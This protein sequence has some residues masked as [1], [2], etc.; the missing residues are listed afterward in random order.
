MSTRGSPGPKLWGF[1][2]WV[3]SWVFCLLAFFDA[4]HL[5]IRFSFILPLLLQTLEVYH[6]LCQQL[7]LLHGSGNWERTNY[8]KAFQPK[9]NTMG[10]VVLEERLEKHHWSLTKVFQVLIACPCWSSTIPLIGKPTSKHME[11]KTDLWSFLVNGYR[12]HFL[13]NEWRNNG[14]IGNMH[15]QV[16]QR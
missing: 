7:L 8:Q 14:M 11:F 5:W 2:S 12:V 3:G 15:T 4:E 9:T 6:Q 13:E 16:S 10:K 1:G